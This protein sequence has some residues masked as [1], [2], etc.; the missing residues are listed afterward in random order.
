MHYV[1]R[2]SVG[3]VER[4]VG[5]FVLLTAVMAASIFYAVARSRGVFEEVQTVR[6]AFQEG[7]GLRPGSLVLL[8]GLEVGTVQAVGFSRDNRVEVTMQVPARHADRIRADSVA[9]V[10]TAGLVGDTVVKI[11]LGSPLRPQVPEGGLIASE[12]PE[13]LGDLATRVRPAVEQVEA[14]VDDLRVVAAHL[15]DQQRGVGHLLEKAD[16]VLE[17]SDRI[18]AEVLEGK[19]SL[20]ALIRSREFYDGLLQLRGETGDVLTDLRAAAAEIRRGAESVPAL[21]GAAQAMLEDGRAV[22]RSLREAS[23]QVPP[24]LRSVRRG[25]DEVSSLL[26][27]ARQRW[28]FSALGADDAPVGGLPA[29]LRDHGYP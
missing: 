23:G 15:A 3:Q 4:L 17:G 16:R 5:L 8:G 27:G 1:H 18:V 25:A 14:L 13:T 22:A 21:V 29:P 24:T 2:L 26:E 6:T 11:S 10:G 7:H 9:S 19:G 20:G 28:P 12:E